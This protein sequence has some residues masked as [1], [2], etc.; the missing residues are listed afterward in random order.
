MN[1]TI[2]IKLLKYATPENSNQ[3]IQKHLLKTAVEI[4]HSDSCFA[5]LR[6]EQ[7]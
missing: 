6:T 3:G 5:I 2:S 7:D 4:F 1:R